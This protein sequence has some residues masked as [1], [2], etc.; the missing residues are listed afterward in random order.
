[1]SINRAYI[2]E[3]AGQ[4]NAPRAGIA[5]VKDYGAVGNGI[6]ND[7]AAIQAAADTGLDVYLPAGTYL[8][9]SQGNHPVTNLG[10][11][12]CIKT[13]VAGQRI[14]G[15]GRALTRIN[16]PNNKNGIVIIHDDCMVSDLWVDGGGSNDG[17]ESSSISSSGAGLKRPIITRCKVTNFDDSG[18]RIGYGTSPLSHSNIGTTG[19]QVTDNYLEDGIEGA[20][21]E[22][23]GARDAIVSG[24][25]VRDTEE[26][27]IR[28]V[29]CINGTVS[30][31]TVVA[32]TLS[33]LNG[34]SLESGT[35]ASATNP[36]YPSSALTCSGNTVTGYATGIRAAFMVDG[37]TISGNNVTGA[38]LYGIQIR[39]WTTAD[40]NLRDVSIAANT[41]V[42]SG[43][44]TTGIY[45]RSSTN[46]DG[47]GGTGKILDGFAITGNV[48][49]GYRDRA[50]YFFGASLD[51]NMRNGQVTGN[52]FLPYD[53]T[54]S[55]TS[56]GVRAEYTSDVVID[57][58]T[59][60][61]ANGREVFITST[62]VRTTRGPGKTRYRVARDGNI[63]KPPIGNTY[64]WAPVTGQQY[65]IESTGT[66]PAPLAVN[67][68]YW[69][70]LLT[71]GW[72]ACSS[73]ANAFAGTWITL[74]DA[75][76]GTHHVVLDGGRDNNV[77]IE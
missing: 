22:V 57:G 28:M 6:A 2:E 12:Y 68:P 51:N 75:G 20:G 63:L 52:T 73:Q 55:A 1:M 15:A 48:I 41:I 30:G 4:A 24:N 16:I 14:Y 42:M 54:D 50:I 19:A 35:D 43:A 65:F 13:A 5:N 27:G 40:Y 72:R 76:T 58:N 77:V 37:L 33:C 23:I 32:G 53:S 39:G 7:T 66:P 44:S 34:I 38:T 61:H 10:T 9:T 74:T 56:D 11:G 45:V 26:W 67:T 25:I 17:T 46:A 69:A 49:S 36:T 71:N 8:V 62:C 21:I 59:F 3:I 60:K 31:N 29:G 70:I 64:G 18:I 47:T